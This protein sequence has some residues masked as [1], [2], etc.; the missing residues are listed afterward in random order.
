MHTCS[1]RVRE[2]GTPTHFGPQF[3]H[4]CIGSMDAPNTECIL[5]TQNPR[6]GHWCRVVATIAR[7]QVHMLWAQTSSCLVHTCT[8]VALAAERLDFLM[9]MKTNWR[10][11]VPLQPFHCHSVIV[12]YLA[13]HLSGQLYTGYSLSI[14]DGAWLPQPELQY[15]SVQVQITHCWFHPLLSTL[16]EE[17]VIEHT[18]IAEMLNL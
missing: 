7:A 6:S 16:V 2:G 13:S 8:A 18:L 9:C 11:D 5:F 4:L 1:E 15:Y 14:W 17:A 12:R 3:L 10:A